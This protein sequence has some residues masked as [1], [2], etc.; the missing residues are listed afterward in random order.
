VPSVRNVGN[1]GQRERTYKKN[2]L[3]NLNQKKSH[4]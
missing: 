2:R 3:L 1:T 4:L